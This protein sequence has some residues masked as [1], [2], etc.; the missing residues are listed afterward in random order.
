MH[1]L[2]RGDAEVAAGLRRSVGAFGSTEEELNA[3]TSRGGPKDPLG[4]Q[5]PGS[6]AA[7]ALAV[8]FGDEKARAR[9]NAQRSGGGGSG[10]AGENGIPFV[11]EE[12]YIVRP[13]TVGPPSNPWGRDSESVDSDSD[14]G[15]ITLIPIC[16]SFAHSRFFLSP[17]CDQVISYCW[18]KHLEETTMPK[19]KVNIKPAEEIAKI[20]LGSDTELLEFGRKLAIAHA[21]G[22]TSDS[23]ANS[24]SNT[25]SLSRPQV[26]LFSFLR[27]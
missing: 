1:L 26:A 11:D 8:P 15:I 9:A 20:K 5:R 24:D 3:I 19:L 27:N 17:S 2:Y 18:P 21:S 4:R 13:A 16:M 6:G 25:T 23:N 10:G 22:E 12:G 7:T 14:Q